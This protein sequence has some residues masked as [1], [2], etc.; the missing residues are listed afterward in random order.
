MKTF[1]NP[2]SALVFLALLAAFLLADTFTLLSQSLQVF[3]DD[4]A[5]TTLLIWAFVKLFVA[6]CYTVNFCF[7]IRLIYINRHLYNE[8]EKS[9]NNLPKY[10]NAPAP[11]SR[12]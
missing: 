7:A 9:E 1:K 8:V 10:E 2:G 12:L 11:P 3:A 4:T 6:F 5:R